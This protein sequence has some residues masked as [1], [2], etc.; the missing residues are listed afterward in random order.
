MQLI[1]QYL[2]KIDTRVVD[3]I[4]NFPYPDITVKH[5]LKYQSSLVN[6]QQILSDKIMESHLIQYH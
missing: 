3:V 4:K 2:L 1:K 5:L 6:Y